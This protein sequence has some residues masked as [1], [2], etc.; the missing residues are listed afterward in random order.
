MGFLGSPFA[1]AGSLSVDQGLVGEDDLPPSDDEYF[2][3]GQQAQAPSLTP[4][5]FR[6]GTQSMPMPQPFQQSVK[7]QA[8]AET[9]CIT[10]GFN[11]QAPAGYTFRR[12]LNKSQS[13]YCPSMS[14]QLQPQPQLQQPQVLPQPQMTIASTDMSLPTKVVLSVAVLVGVTLVARKLM[15][16]KA[17]TTGD[18]PCPCQEK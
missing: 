6:P 15:A 18:A 7:P 17:A 10:V 16:R 4:S 14:P 1:G 2:A 12:M 3:P 13:L 9:G 8:S 11:Q 5:P